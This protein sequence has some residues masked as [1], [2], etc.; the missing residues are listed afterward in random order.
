MVQVNGGYCKE[1]LI[2]GEAIPLNLQ[3]PYKVLTFE[4]LPIRKSSSKSIR[5]FNKSPIPVHLSFEPSLQSL[6]ELEVE[7]LSPVEIKM[8]GRETLDIRLR[9]SPTKRTSFFSIPCLVKAEGKMFELFKIQG[10]SKA[11]EVQ[12]S[13][14]VIEFGKVL[15]GAKEKRVVFVE[16]RGDL[17]TPFCWS[18]TNP[19]F[20]VSPEQGILSTNRILT[21]QIYFMPTQASENSVSGL[22]QCSIPG[23]ESLCFRTVL[24]CSFRVPSTRFG[25]AR[26]RSEIQC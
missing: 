21:L 13:N 22:I 8:N 18:S 5:I 26:H 1:C 15:E 9:F 11:P 19:Q 12:I 23:M 24:E 3:I 10:K 6:S 7:L 25:C 20:R 4:G 2:R 16:N 14:T 17:E